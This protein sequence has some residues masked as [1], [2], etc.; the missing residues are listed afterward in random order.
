MSDEPSTEDRGPSDDLLAEVAHE[1]TNPLA[2]AQGFA[3]TLLDHPELG[4]EGRQAAAAVDRNV[5]IA[6]QLLNNYREAARPG[7]DPITLE[8]EWVQVADLARWTVADLSS[9]TNAHEIDVEPPDTEIRVLADEGRLRQALFNLLSNAVK[10]TPPEAAIHV[11]TWQNE[12]SVT[13]E[14]ADE[15]DGVAPA[16]A[17]RIFEPRFQGEDAPEGLGLG[18]YVAKRIAEAHGGDL[19]LVPAENRGATFH[20]TLPVDEDRPA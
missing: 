15:G 13:I 9:I 20:L 14:V 6:L 5:R 7:D 19:E 8:L 4:E 10:H 17:D 12:R 11:R 18:L 1:L 16:V 3:A 2:I